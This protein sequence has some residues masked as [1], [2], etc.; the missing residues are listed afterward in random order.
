M[1]TTKVKCE[2]CKLDFDK[3]AREVRRSIKLGTPS[4][5]QNKNCRSEWGRIT[6]KRRKN[7]NGGMNANWMRK[8]NPSKRD[9]YSPFR[10]L[11]H[12]IR[13]RKYKNNLTIEELKLMWDKQCGK[14]AITGLQ[15]ILP[16]TTASTN[17]G[18]KCVS[19]DRIDNTKGYDLN[20][21][22]L[23]CYSANLARNSFS[24]EDIKN[25]FNEIGGPCQQSS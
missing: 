15:M 10:N 23:V 4:I 14:C 25:F 6:M 22:Q 21:V 11:L 9:C 7:H 3:S 2:V 8:I 17:V 18:P 13:N 19:I 12:K 1:I 5:C 20:N 16:E 24:I